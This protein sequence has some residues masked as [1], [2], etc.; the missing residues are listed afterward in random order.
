M[1]TNKLNSNSFFD[2]LKKQIGEPPESVRAKIRELFAIIREDPIIKCI[3][4]LREQA[5]VAERS[6]ASQL[7]SIWAAVVIKYPRIRY[8]SAGRDEDG[9][10]H[11]TWA[12]DDLPDITFAI[13]VEQ[14]GLVSWFFRDRANSIVA[15]TEDE[16]ESELPEAALE[17]L[18]L[19]EEPRNCLISYTK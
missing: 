18:K 17:R 15:G 10:Y 9:V 5:E 1:A 3:R 7:L 19:W 11:L 6:Q 4:M 12:F 14:N 13:E 2:G 16:G 8:P